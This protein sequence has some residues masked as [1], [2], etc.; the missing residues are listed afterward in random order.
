M[1]PGNREGT[2]RE[3][4]FQPQ[5]KAGPRRAK[6]NKKQQLAK[7][8]DSKPDRPLIVWDEGGYGLHVLVKPGRADRQAKVILRV[9]Y[10]LKG[11]L[12]KPRYKVLG[13]WPDGKYEHEGS[14]YLCSDIKSIRLVAGL[15]RKNA[16]EGND[17]RRDLPSN[18]FGNVASDF[19]QQYAKKKTRT[20]WESERILN[21]YVLSEWRNLDITDLK[22]STVTTL[23]DKIE[24]KRLKHPKTGQ[25][26]GGTVTADATLAVLSKLCRHMTQ[27]PINQSNIMYPA[28][29]C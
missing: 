7:L 2:A 18:A 12:G 1:A 11:E 10:Y 19:I 3:Q 23:L 21:T 5:L 26:V 15:I 6:F 4:P 25:L 13:H 22:R 29:A 20:W 27:W 24:T 14:T 8:L 17:P 28:A 9:C 16:E